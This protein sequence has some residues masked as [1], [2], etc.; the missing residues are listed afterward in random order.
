MDN[1]DDDDDDDGVGED[2]EEEDEEE[3]DKK[4][5]KMI[6]EEFVCPMILYKTASHLKNPKSE[7]IYKYIDRYDQYNSSFF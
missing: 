3:E 4:V 6:G 7:K 1:D 5:I 2:E